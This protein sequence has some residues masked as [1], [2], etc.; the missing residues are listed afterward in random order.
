ME[1]PCLPTAPAY[2]DLPPAARPLEDTP[3]RDELP[4]EELPVVDEPLREEPIVEVE[5]FF[6]LPEVIS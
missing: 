3:P 5:L 1:A 6:E 2:D 4:A